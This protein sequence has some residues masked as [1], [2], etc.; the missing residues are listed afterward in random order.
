LFE[1]LITEINIKQLVPLLV[2]I[3]I[4]I[5]TTYHTHTTTYHTHRP[6]HTQTQTQTQTYNRITDTD[7]DPQTK[8][9]RQ[10][11]RHTHTNRNRHTETDRH[12]HRHRQDPTHPHRAT[13][14]FSKPSPRPI[15]PKPTLCVGRWCGGLEAWYVGDGMCGGGC[16]GGECNTCKAWMNAT[17]HTGPSICVVRPG[18]ITLSQC[19][20][21]K[22]VKWPRLLMC[23]SEVALN[24]DGVQREH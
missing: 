17:H 11:D 3:L 18:Q 19:S 9:H 15:H 7:T 24:C 20:A 4:I 10:T 13:L 1:P 6:T 2:N 16:G 14:P 21:S 23:L 8:I 5:I 12:K 22:L